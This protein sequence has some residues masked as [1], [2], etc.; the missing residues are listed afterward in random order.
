MNS[1]SFILKLK[2]NKRQII[3]TLGFYTLRRSV[4][5]FSILALAYFFGWELSDLRE[6]QILGLPLY[7]LILAIV[8]TL[9]AMRLKQLYKWW[10][11]A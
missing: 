6:F 11:N 1:R 3:R 2:D 4:Y 8:T 5:G 10:N 9:I 7:F